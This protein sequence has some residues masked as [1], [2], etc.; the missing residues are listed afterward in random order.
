MKLIFLVAL[1]SM[2]VQSL[3]TSDVLEFTDANFDS[4][5][6]NH[7]IALVE[8]YAP[9][10][11]HCKKLAPEY[12]KAAPILKENDPPVALIKVDCTV[13]TKVCGKYGVS[14]YPTLK[15]FKNGEMISDYNGPR[16]ADGI[17]KYMRTKAGPTSKELNTVEEVEKFLSNNEHSIV[18]FF[19]TT[20]SSLATE[21]KKVAD[22][23]AENYRFA[24]SSNPDVLVKYNH[25]DKVVIYQPPRLQVK[26]EPTETVYTGSASSSGIKTFI[27]TDLH[28]TVGHRTAGNAQDFRNPLVVVYF[29]V[30]FVRDVKGSNYVRNRV[31][32]V[33]QK[34]R[35]ENIKMNFAISNTEEFKGELAEFGVE[36]PSA[37]TKYIIGRGPGNEKYK[38]EGEYSVENLEKF[39]RDLVAGSLVP[40]LKSEP[41]PT[42]NPDAVRTVVAKNFDQVVNDPT[43]DVLIEFYAPWCGHCK[44]L[45]PKYEDLAK[46]LQ[47]EDGIV[48]AK[49][50]ATAN[51][52]PSQYSVQGF[53]TIFFAPKNNKQNPRKYEGGR[54]VDDFV[55]YLAKEAS[56]P[57]K[58]FD[59]SGKKL[60]KK[61]DL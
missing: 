8:F 28:G 27:Q 6:S 22:Q 60:K 42:E 1:I 34:L 19:K 10:C 11:G 23:L 35:G 50:D 57:L 46:K 12:E 61:T 16:E 41:V 49:M 32:K 30:D 54:E 44:S 47:D 24:Y 4:K 3:L 5:I 37:D 31:I 17:V 26:L 45:A 51:D 29:N 59:R 58:N 13:E 21:F 43:K 53:P 18:G 48:I 39:A 15:I 55:K 2:F 20:T 52:V 14:G 7:E 56:D 40:Y 38:F 36:E 33:A 25:E 9:W